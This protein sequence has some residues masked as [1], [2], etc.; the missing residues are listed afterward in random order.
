[1]CWYEGTIVQFGRRG[2]HEVKYTDGESEWLRLTDECIRFGVAA[3]SSSPDGEGG[4]GGGGEK[5]AKAVGIS[6]G[7][8]AMERLSRMSERQ[9]LAFL[10]QATAKE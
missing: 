2:K 3:S 4:G 10:L 7:K 6:M 1:M 8:R 9:Q 5:P